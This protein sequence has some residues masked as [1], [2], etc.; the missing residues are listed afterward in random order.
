MDN[1]KV[2]ID[3]KT[4]DERIKELGKQIE[5]DYE[6]KEIVLDDIT[7]KGRFEALKLQKFNVFN[8]SHK[9]LSDL[10]EENHINHAAK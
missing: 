5:K 6:G 4:L 8:K 10:L 7:N 3:K 9:L 2:L 1:I